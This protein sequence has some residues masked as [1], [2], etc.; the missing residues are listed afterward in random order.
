MN[1][2]DAR[3]LLAELELAEEGPSQRRT[4]VSLCPRF[5]TVGTRTGAENRLAQT[6]L[7][8]ASTST[9][10]LEGQRLAVAEDRGGAGKVHKPGHWT[11][12]VLPLCALRHWR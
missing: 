11:S 12:T 10:K 1:E 2:S 8:M 4:Q 5:K 3:A 9:R 6:A 7:V